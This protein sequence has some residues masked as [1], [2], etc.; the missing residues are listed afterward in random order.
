MLKDIEKLKESV[1]AI[2]DLLKDVEVR[3]E[4]NAFLDGQLYAID[5]VL[6]L[7]EKQKEG[8]NE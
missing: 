8:S 5:A 7:I 1:A 4:S 2:K 6:R 3:N